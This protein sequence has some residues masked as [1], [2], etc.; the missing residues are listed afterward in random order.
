MLAKCKLVII[1]YVASGLSF[2]ISSCWI[3]TTSRR[4]IKQLEISLGSIFLLFS[5][6]NSRGPRS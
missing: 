5:Y 3:N 1:V 2:K 4:V 6:E